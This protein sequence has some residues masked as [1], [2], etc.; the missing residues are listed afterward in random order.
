MK[1]NLVKYE[2]A[3]YKGKEV[4]FIRFEYEAALNERV[5]KLVGVQWS[6][7]QKAWHVLDSSQY[8]EKFGLPP[9]SLVGKETLL[10]IQSINVPAMQLY[11]ETL[12]LKAYSI[13]TINTYRNEFAQMLYILKDKYV[14]DL[15]QAG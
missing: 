2:L 6:Q 4:I 9:K 11:V 14:N 12:Q 15:M 7:S 1:N 10:H 8:R 13:N 5:K 3:T